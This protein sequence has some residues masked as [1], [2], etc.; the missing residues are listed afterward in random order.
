MYKYN[1]FDDHGGDL[2]DVDDDNDEESKSGE[3]GK[4]SAG[5]VA[6]Y[7][8]RSLTKVRLARPCIYSSG[9]SD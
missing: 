5:R 6:R 1:D 4:G 7:W 3:I 2:D 9:G 8:S